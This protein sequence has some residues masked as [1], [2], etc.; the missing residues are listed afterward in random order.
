MPGAL[1]TLSQREFRAGYAEVAKYG[2]I[3]DREFFEWLEA[4]LARR[5]RRRPGAAAT[6]SR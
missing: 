6:R 5:V 3:D 4:Q 2:L 1:D